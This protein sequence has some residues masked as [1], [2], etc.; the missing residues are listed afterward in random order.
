MARKKTKPVKKILKLT[1]YQVMKLSDENLKTY[2]SQLNAAANK[3]IKRAQKQGYTS[4]VIERVLQKPEGKFSI[5][6]LDKRSKMEA[7]FMDVKQFMEAKTST[8]RGIKKSQDKMFKA[9]AEKVNADLPPDEKIEPVDWYKDKTDQQIK[10]ITD[11]VWTQVDKL[12]EN[13]QFGITKKE[14]YAIAA[15]AFEVVTRTRR[16]VTDKKSLYQNLKK[17]YQEEYIR[18]V[19]SDEDVIQLTEEEEKIAQMYRD[20]T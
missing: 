13:K 9:L 19:E 4:G 20:F 16:P 17:F 12:A 11:L 18:S 2:V 5:R 7:A 10:D 3:R 8:G 1:A 15:H 6:G 14:R